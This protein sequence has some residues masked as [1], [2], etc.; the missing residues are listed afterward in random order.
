M[1][2]ITA[3]SIRKPA[4]SGCNGERQKSKM[5]GGEVH[6]PMLVFA[7]S[8]ILRNQASSFKDVLS[9]R[10]FR[11]VLAVLTLA[12]LSAAP[13]LTGGP[14]SPQAIAQTQIAA[15]QLQALSGEYTNSIEPDTPLSFYFENGKLVIESE[16]MVPT[17]LN[18]SSAND[19]GFPRAF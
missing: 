9:L 5:E 8:A 18:A 16:R 19:F 7:Y 3:T 2:I 1:V 15:G 12:L 17:E 11:A 13:G 6:K 10:R 14:A 4:R